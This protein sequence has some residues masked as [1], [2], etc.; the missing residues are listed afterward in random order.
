MRPSI[1]IA[2]QQV[3]ESRVIV[4]VRPWRHGKRGQKHTEVIRYKIFC[5]QSRMM[6]SDSR[7]KPLASKVAANHPSSYSAD[8]YPLWAIATGTF[9][10][11]WLSQAKMPVGQLK[12]ILGHNIIF[13][14]HVVMRIPIPPHHSAWKTR[15]KREIMWRSGSGKI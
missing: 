10:K 11:S 5:M 9:Q 15:I 8:L 7:S 4:T 1:C 2:V 12:Q 6:V 13:L 3:Y 14:V